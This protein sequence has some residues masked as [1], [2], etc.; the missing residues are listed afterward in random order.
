MTK[1]S[2]S[3]AMI[4]TFFLWMF[5]PSFNAGI[6]PLNQFEKSLVISNTILSLA[7]SCLSAIVASILIRKNRKIDIED[8]LNATLAGG[9]I[10]GAP[11]GVLTNS[12]GAIAIGFIGG[13]I[14]T[15]CFAKL[16]PKLKECMRLDDTCG[17][18]NLHG[19]PGI[20]GGLIS[21]IV[22][23][24][25]HAD[26]MDENI[27][28]FLTFYSTNNGAMSLADQSGIQVACTFISL[29]IAI[30]AG[31]IV[32]VIIRCFINFEND[33]LYEDGIYFAVPDEAEEEVHKATDPLKVSSPQKKLLPPIEKPSEIVFNASNSNLV[34]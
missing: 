27:Q 1:I 21:A 12:G 13:A 14:S 24:A 28:T 11:A 29:A 26:P 23:R 34:E 6:F 18:H 10:I 9:V 31:F 20:L 25:Y 2:T 15:L 5:W 22:V 3:M 4:G 8:V 33:E 17:V 30:A 16:G 19:I 7:G 32:G